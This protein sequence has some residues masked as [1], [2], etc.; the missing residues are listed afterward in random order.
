M[1]TDD[2]RALA[3]S[4]ARMNRDRVV[5]LSPEPWQWS[6][7]RV[8]I[9]DRDEVR[10]DARAATFRRNGYA[11]AVCPGP[12]PG[13]ACPLA[14]ADDGCAAAV[15][16]DVIVS[17]LGL[18]AAEARDALAALRSRAP[19]VPLLLA[20]DVGD[21]VRWPDLVEGCDVVPAGATPEQIVTRAGAMVAQESNDGA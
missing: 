4:A 2:T 1:L 13:G 16:A 5:R 14:T 21:V 9:E 6:R 11:V 18:G 7:P 8:L 10:A 15:G 20:A 3:R 12:S 19:A 17:S